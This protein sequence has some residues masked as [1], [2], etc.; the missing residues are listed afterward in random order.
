M[1]IVI[2]EAASFAI[3]ISQKK[4]PLV[5]PL[6]P[7]IKRQSV[8]LFATPRLP[9]TRSN[10]VQFTSKQE[11]I[12]VVEINVSLVYKSNEFVLGNTRLS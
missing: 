9:Q 5:S 11:G 1:A 12:D 8:C 10:S 6:S 2:C 3:Y 7:E 4:L